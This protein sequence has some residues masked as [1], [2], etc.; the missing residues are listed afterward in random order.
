MEQSLARAGTA[1]ADA[2]T[3]DELLARA[4]AAGVVQGRE[5]GRLTELFYEA[6]FSSHPVPPAHRDE[7][8]AALEVLAADLRD[9]IA[10]RAAEAEAAAQAAEAKAAQAR[11]TAGRG[12]GPAR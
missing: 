5:A 7:A 8:R 4:A 2:E 3:P 1:R 12:D 11:A 9:K 10:R 6:R